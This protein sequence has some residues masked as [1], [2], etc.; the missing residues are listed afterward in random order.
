MKN[1]SPNRNDGAFFFGLLI[2][3]VM[4]VAGCAYHHRDPAS[5]KM[6]NAQYNAAQVC[7]VRE[8]KSADWPVCK[9]EPYRAIG[10]PE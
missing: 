4:T 1:T 2:T 6:P 7:E 3:F 8:I 5:Y 10:L 9:A